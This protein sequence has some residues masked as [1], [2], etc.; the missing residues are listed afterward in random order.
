MQGSCTQE[1]AYR[2]VLIQKGMLASFTWAWCNS[3]SLSLIPPFIC[4][5]PSALESWPCPLGLSR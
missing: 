1:P 2:R 4:A 5:K 3:A